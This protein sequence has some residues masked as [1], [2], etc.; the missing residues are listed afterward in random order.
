MQTHAL[1]F[2]AALGVTALA[3][4]QSTNLPPAPPAAS[5]PSFTLSEQV[6]DLRGFDD[7]FA[8]YEVRVGGQPMAADEQ[9]NRWLAELKAGRARAGTLAGSYLSYRALTSAD[10]AAARDA[11]VAADEL[12]SDQAPWSLAQLAENSS[13]GAI[14]RAQVEKW[15]KKAVTLDYLASA[16]RLS[17][18][19]SGDQPGDPLQQYMYAR[20]AAGYWEAV[21]NGKASEQSRAGFDPAA[22]LEMEKKISAADRTHA[23]AE[24]AKIL[25]QMLKRHERFGAVKPAEFARGGAGGKAAHEFVAYTADYRHE[26]QW[27]LKSNCNGAQRLAFVDVTSKNAEFLGCKLELQ[28]RDFVT[29]ATQPLKREFLIGPKATRRVL[30]GDVSAIPDKK[31]V[32]TICAPVPNLAANAAAGKCRARLQG[33]IDAAEFYPESAKARGLEGNAVVRFWVPPDSDTVADA[34][35]ATSSGDATLD[36]AAIATVRSGKFARDCAYGLGSIRIAF[37]L[38]N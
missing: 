24:A 23:E 14:D 28:A 13:C 33:T 36:D 35:I 5:T 1:Y 18:Y 3:A 10:C 7:A 15:H 20:V 30:L 25:A 19:S 29:G 8:L 11:L 27:N 31:A 21:S 2:L 17:F 38:Q 22:L 6:P 32:A 34:E 16:Q 12:G 9:L 37:K 26:C 4:A